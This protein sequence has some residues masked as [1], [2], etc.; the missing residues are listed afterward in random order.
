MK[1]NLKNAVSLVLAVFV[2]IV[3][4][5]T[6]AR[7]G[8][9]WDYGY[10]TWSGAIVMHLFTIPLALMAL[11]LLECQKKASIVYTAFVLGCFEHWLCAAAVFVTLISLMIEAGDEVQCL[12]CLGCAMLVMPSARA[13]LKNLYSFG[14]V[15]SSYIDDGDDKEGF[16]KALLKTYLK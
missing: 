14:Y 5:S 13:I 12:L 6:L 4:V 8:N 9:V 16:N 11:R 3:A 2:V 15:W 10:L 1:K 7:I